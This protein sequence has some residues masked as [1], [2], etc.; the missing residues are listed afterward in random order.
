MSRKTL[1]ASILALGLTFAPA[2]ATAGDGAACAQEKATLQ[3]VIDKHLKALGGRERLQ[4]AKT[5]QLTALLKEGDKVTTSTI[6]RARPN[7]MRTD[8]EGGGTRVSKVFDGQQGW[9]VEG[10]AAPQRLDAET[11]AIVA[12]TASFDDVLMDP[13]ARGFTVTLAGVEEVEGAPAYKLV[14]TRG[15]NSEIR[16]IDQERF[17]EVRRTYAGTYQGKA[18][19]KTVSFF[20]YRAVDGIQVSHR[21]TWVSDD[22]EKGEK[23][24]QSVRYDAPIDAATFKPAAAPRS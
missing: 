16:L 7:L 23:T 5:F 20:D 3:T 18:F 17:L 4:A 21:T 8:V 14:L 10:T 9:K 24:V 2:I 22:G 19:R 11:N 13:K 12:D 15:A 1:A 6:R